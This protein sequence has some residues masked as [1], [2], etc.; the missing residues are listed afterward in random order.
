[1]I[2]QGFKY[3]YLKTSTIRIPSSGALKLALFEQDIC[4]AGKL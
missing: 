1:M 4:M 2:K 3:R